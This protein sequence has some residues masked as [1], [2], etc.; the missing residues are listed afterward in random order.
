M[1]LFSANTPPVQAR[2]D[3]AYGHCDRPD[4]MGE[5]SDR[6]FRASIEAVAGKASAVPFSATL[7]DLLG[8][9]FAPVTAGDDGSLL[10]RLDGA[11]V[12]LTVPTIRQHVRTANVVTQLGVQITDAAI[13]AALPIVTRRAKAERER[14]V[15]A[16]DA[17]ADRERR[18]LAEDVE[19][20]EKRARL[21]REL[22]ELDTPPSAPVADV[23]PVP[24]PP[25][26]RW[27][28]S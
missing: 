7:A 25:P 20:A 21:L 16:A 24:G 2:P 14:D 6:D 22:A 11:T 19:V 9:W 8:A 15:V 4:W 5:E 12:Q 27:R 23:R 13:T 18:E 26:K 3:A 10:G 1:S 17:R 28:R